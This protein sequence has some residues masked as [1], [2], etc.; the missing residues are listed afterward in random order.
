MVLLNF[1]LK[2]AWHYRKN[3]PDTSHGAGPAMPRVP[4]AMEEDD[5]GS[6]L[7]AGGHHH[8]LR[9]PV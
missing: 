9:H 4:Q 7:A 8:R 6:V 1:M 2:I 5:G 3:S